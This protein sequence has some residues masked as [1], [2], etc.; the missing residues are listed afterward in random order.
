[1]LLFLV[2]VIALLPKKIRFSSKE[3]IYL[4]AENENGLIIFFALA[5]LLIILVFS[6]GR[7]D[8]IGERGR[9]TALYE[10][11]II[12]FILG[13][14]YSGKNKKYII[15]L[16]GMLF[17]FVF[18][19]FIFGERIGAIQ[20]L[21]LWFLMIV[22]HRAKLTFVAPVVILGIIGMNVIGSLS[23]NVLY[24]ISYSVIGDVAVRTL[25]NS[26]ALDTAYSAYH[27]S[28]T[29]LASEQF[30]SM[31]SR[32]D[33]FFRFLASMI[34]GGSNVEGSSLGVITGNYFNH[35]SGGILPY[36]FH[37]YLG[38]FGV[39]LVSVA[40]GLIVRWISSKGNMNVLTAPYQVLLGLWLSVTV[41]R[42]FLYSP[43]SLIRGVVL[44]SLVYALSLLLSRKKKI[45]YS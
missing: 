40:V 25:E 27:T 5:V 31:D 24:D 22:A 34:L 7:P 15:L 12:F 26:F 29:F 43:S 23:G 39:L 10:Y 37:F 14:Y 3:N 32:L 35:H 8:Q 41:F 21:S 42:W 30:L 33:L 44:F 28:L 2:V 36:Y 6:F 19:N 45:D 16:S 9:M 18:Q 11:S 38:I 1:M 13:F 17:L 20:L 4:K